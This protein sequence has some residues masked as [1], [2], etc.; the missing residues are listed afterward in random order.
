MITQL[1][2]G[3]CLDFFV[4][5]NGDKAPNRE[6]YDIFRFLQCPQDENN[7]APFWCNGRHWC[8]YTLTTTNTRE[9]ALELCKSSAMH[10][11]ALLEMDNWEI[12]S[13]YP[14]KVFVR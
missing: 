12:K 8:A 7:P 5:M 3:G 9:K 2:K 14:Y 1:Y 13:D 4:D 6:G 10:C 11:S